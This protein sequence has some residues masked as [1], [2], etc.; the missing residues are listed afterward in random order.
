MTDQRLIHKFDVCLYKNDSIST[1]DFTQYM[2]ETY[3][4]KATA[5]V[6]RHGLL[7]TCAMGGVSQAH[8]TGTMGWMLNLSDSLHTD[9]HAPKAIASRTAP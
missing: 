1:E 3:L 4:P 7:Q 6:K 2:K 8:S 9:V 5:V